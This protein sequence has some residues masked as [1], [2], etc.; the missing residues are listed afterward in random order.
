MGKPPGPCGHFIEQV[1]GVK[2]EEETGGGDVLVGERTE[3]D[4]AE[5]DKQDKEQ[6]EERAGEREELGWGRWPASWG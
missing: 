6:E 2:D 3:E 1:A 4:M 5:V